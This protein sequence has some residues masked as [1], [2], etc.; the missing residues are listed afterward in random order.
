MK[1]FTCILPELEPD[2]HEIIQDNGM[3]MHFYDDGNPTF[4]FHSELQQCSKRIFGYFK[5]VEHNLNL[6]NPSAIIVQCYHN[7][8]LV[9]VNVLVDGPNAFILQSSTNLKN[10]TVN[11]FSME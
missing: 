11:V 1:K 7:G 8:V 6:E 10:I 4:V 2:I 3:R 5:R 9:T